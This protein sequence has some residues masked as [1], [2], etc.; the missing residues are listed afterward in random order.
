M[1]GNFTV[2][3]LLSVLHVVSGGQ[4]SHY[5]TENELTPPEGTVRDMTPHAEGGDEGTL[6]NGCRKRANEIYC[7]KSIRG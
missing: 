7:I 5:M 4:C 3:S 6:T 1:K 2:I